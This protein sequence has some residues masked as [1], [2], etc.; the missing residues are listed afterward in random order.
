MSK[1]AKRKAAK[2]KTEAEDRAFWESRDSVDYVNWSKAKQVNFPNL[3][4]TTESISLRL[5]VAMLEGLKIEANSET[6]L[7]N[8]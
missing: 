2:F 7:I 8:R 1:I 5:P 6:F 3:K 4:A